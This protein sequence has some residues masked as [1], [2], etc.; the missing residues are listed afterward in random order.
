MAEDDEFLE[1]LQLLEKHNGDSDLRELCVERVCCYALTGLNFMRLQCLLPKLS[2]IICI[3]RAQGGLLLY[4]FSKLRRSHR[5]AAACASQRRLVDHEPQVRALLACVAP[6][7]R[8][9][10]AGVISNRRMSLCFARLLLH[11]LP[12]PSPCSPI[13][14]LA[15]LP[16]HR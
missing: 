13:P 11:L 2:V 14:I 12:P 9:T 15:A 4:V 5:A 6:L 1:Q 8:L 7:L 16:R 10:Q 3:A